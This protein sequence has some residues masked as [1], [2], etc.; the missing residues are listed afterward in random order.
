MLN[1][2]DGNSRRRRL[3]DPTRVDTPLKHSLSSQAM[4]HST[5]FT[6]FLC[7][8]NYAQF[9]VPYTLREEC[10]WTCAPK[11]PI[12]TTK[13]PVA[14][15]SNESSKP[16]AG[17]SILEQIALVDIYAEPLLRASQV[18]LD[19]NAEPPWDPDPIA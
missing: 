12:K 8:K 16:P 14:E 5:F 17:G 6:P 7:L 19:K 15:E 11:L 1:S 9:I 18:Q 2:D 13:I 4:A 3:Y 10:V